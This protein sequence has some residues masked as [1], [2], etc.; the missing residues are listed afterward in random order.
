MTA[1]AAA[2]GP[3]GPNGAARGAAD[4]NGER[5]LVVGGYGSL[6]AAVS[7][8]LVAQGAKVAVAGRSI[9][10]AKE[11]A[12]R[13]PGP[14]IAAAHA[15][16]VA[17]RADVGRLVDAVVQDWGGVDVLINCASVLVTES[18]QEIT[19][20]SWRQIT[21]IN[22]L[23][24][25]WLSQS[26]G[27]AMIA[28][29][30]GGRIL[31]LSSVRGLLGARR[32]FTAYGASKA[33]LDLLVKQLAAEWGQYQVTV[34]AVAPGFVRTE[35]VEMAASDPA[36]MR[37]VVSRIPLGRTAEVHEVADAVV[38]MASPRASFI[39]GQVL[40]VDGGVTTSQ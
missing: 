21:D 6:G 4:Y 24:A 25:F 40:Y 37:R 31:H 15:V 27:N 7:E 29:G 22:L 12:A 39:T 19:E 35:F 3:D 38:F 8:A 33:G 32:G 23:G 1:G 16:D 20:E 10:R 14:G 5:V 9:D 17:D 30:R 18:A 13:L 36:F 11:L 34:N 2:N 26:V 28:A